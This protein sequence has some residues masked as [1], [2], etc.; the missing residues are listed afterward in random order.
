MDVTSLNIFQYCKF[1]RHTG[2]I[3][4]LLVLAIVGL[5]GYAVFDTFLIPHLEHDS[6]GLVVL[7]SFISIIYVALVSF[8]P[9]PPL[10]LFFPN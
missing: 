5:A 4:L 6:A 2:K 10:S 7:Y 3:M 8:L 9:S 1:L